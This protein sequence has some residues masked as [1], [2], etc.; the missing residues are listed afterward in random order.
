MNL[1]GE[2]L[3]SDIKRFYLSAAI[4]PV[5]LLA[6]AACGTEDAD[7]RG[8][9]NG[10]AVNL[11]AQTGTQTLGEISFSVHR[12]GTGR[13][14]LRAKARAGRVVELT[15]GPQ[16]S[17][18]PIRLDEDVRG[19]Q[20]FV[21]GT[22]EGEGGSRHVGWVITLDRGGWETLSLPFESDAPIR[23]PVDVNDDGRR[24]F[25]VPD[26]ALALVR[27]DNHTIGGPER[28]YIVKDGQ[29]IDQSGHEQYDARRRQQLALA[30]EACEAL[31]TMDACTV[32]G[33]WAARAQRL[34]EAW[35]L[36]RQLAED[37]SVRF[38]RTKDGARECEP[39]S[40]DGL[41]LSVPEAIQYRLATAG[42][43]QPVFLNFPGRTDTSFG[44]ARAATIAERTIC[45]DETLKALERRETA[46]S[47]RA[48]A[49]SADRQAVFD[50]RMAF[51][52]QRNRTIGTAALTELYR[53]RLEQLES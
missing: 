37:P 29:I 2:V 41:D 8:S 3:R 13:S 50:D 22:R 30:K 4:F 47:F 19:V 39:E 49:L 31:A 5:A 23:A 27:L 7:Q 15:G 17:V 52:A 33:A 45:G 1:R 42:Y 20:F 25:V 26:P 24:E 51:L 6:L 35:P 44:C 12:A 53:Q 46:A 9:H 11:T 21:A 28:Y 16:F 36:I 18:T 14:V 48:Q 43:I 40:P 10:D 34:D 38:C 32:Y